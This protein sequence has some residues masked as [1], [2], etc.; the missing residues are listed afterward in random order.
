MVRGIAE[1]ICASYTAAYLARV[2]YSISPDAKDYLM[3]LTE[4]SFQITEKAIREGNSKCETEEQYFQLFEPSIDWLFQCLGQG[5]T[6]KL[7]KDVYDLY[8]QSVNKQ[9]I[10]L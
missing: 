4:F 1:P 10:F 3:V 9:A 5:A 6:K 8:Y 7:F 2:G